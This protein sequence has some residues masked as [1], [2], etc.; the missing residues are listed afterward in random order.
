MIRKVLLERVGEPTRQRVPIPYRNVPD[1]QSRSQV[2]QCDNV[3]TVCSTVVYCW[4]SFNEHQ[5][6]TVYVDNFTLLQE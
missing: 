5:E 2:D 4:G 3:R 6:D 1:F